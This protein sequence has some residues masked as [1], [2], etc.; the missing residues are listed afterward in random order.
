MPQRWGAPA[1]AGT[2]CHE[3]W[4]KFSVLQPP[5]GQC[6]G[7]A[8]GLWVAVWG[9]NTAAPSSWCPA[10]LP[11]APTSSHTPTSILSYSLRGPPRPARGP[12]PGCPVTPPYPGSPPRQ[13]GAQTLLQVNILHFIFFFFLPPP[14]SDFGESQFL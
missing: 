2:H 14:S 4:A 6:L 13:V 3:I 7:G 10:L 12:Q 8:G 11:S 1:P 5:P 9:G